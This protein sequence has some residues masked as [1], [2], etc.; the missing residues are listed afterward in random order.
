MCFSLVF[1]RCLFL[2]VSLY[3]NANYNFFVDHRRDI[4]LSDAGRQMCIFR[5]RHYQEKSQC[6]AIFADGGPA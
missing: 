1:S 6:G 2:G 5:L 3:L 4:L